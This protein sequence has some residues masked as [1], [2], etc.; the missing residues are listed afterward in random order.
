MEKS[1]V[2]LVYVVLKMEST[3]DGIQQ[4]IKSTYI[5]RYCNAA[6][7]YETVRFALL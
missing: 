5:Y 2:V 3:R 4:Q 6:D 1:N 7:A